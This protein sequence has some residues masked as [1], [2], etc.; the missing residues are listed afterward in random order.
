MRWITACIEHLISLLFAIALQQTASP[1][2]EA[3][4]DRICRIFPNKG[5]AESIRTLYLAFLLKSDD[6]TFYLA[7]LL[8]RDAAE[9]PQ[10]SNGVAVLAKARRKLCLRQGKKV[11]ATPTDEASPLYV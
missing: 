1:Q 6:L 10:N 7:F 9:K 5:E 8:G 4:G 11:S 3:E 2:G